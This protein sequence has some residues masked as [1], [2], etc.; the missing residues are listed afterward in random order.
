[1]HG[2]TFTHITGAVPIAH[3]SLYTLTYTGTAAKGL[4]GLRH[5][6]LWPCR[7]WNPGGNRNRPCRRLLYFK[8]ELSSHKPKGCLPIWLPIQGTRLGWSPLGV[9]KWQLVTLAL[10]LPLSLGRKK[11]KKKESCPLYPASAQF[12]LLWRAKSIAAAHSFSKGIGELGSV[13]HF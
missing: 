3:F 5:M 10:S 7:G 12:H 13:R 4:G 9:C 6:V 8:K 1:M 2:M 11:K